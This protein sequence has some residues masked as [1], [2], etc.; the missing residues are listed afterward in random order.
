L[1]IILISGKARNCKSE[2]AKILK[3]KLETKGNKVL[4]TAFGNLVKFVCEK[5]FNSDG[6]KNE[7]NRSLWQ[8][9]GTD[10][11]RKQKPNYWVDFIISIISMFPNE[12]NY[13]IID[14]CR[15]VNEL[16]RYDE[17]WDTTTVRVN[18]LN[19]ESNLTPEQKNHPS[20]TALDN[21]NFDY[22]INSES[23]LDN[24]EKEVDKFLKWMEEMDETD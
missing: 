12:W 17:T 6:Q 14:D 21:Y 11:I 18:R 4:T 5:F 22:V 9:I 16:N 1:K 23:G 13:V 24:L 20:E 7:Y 15:F 2:T 19:F 10:V 3:N 8:R